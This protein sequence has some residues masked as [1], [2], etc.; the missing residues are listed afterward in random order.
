[1]KK[2]FVQLFSVTYVWTQPYMEY[3]E[4]MENEIEQQLQKSE[5]KEATEVINYIKN[6]V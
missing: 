1:M 3:I 4:F 2:E 5:F 6:K